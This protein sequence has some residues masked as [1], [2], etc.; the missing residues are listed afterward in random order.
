MNHA[1]HSKPQVPVTIYDQ[2]VV[3]PP[4]YRAS[5]YGRDIALF[6][7]CKLN[8]TVYEPFSTLQTCKPAFTPSLPAFFTQPN[9]TQKK[10][11][12]WLDK[13]ELHNYH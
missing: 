10:M 8:R 6:V 4:P 7:F 12:V 3:D 11:L 13:T 1:H 5:F 9:F 2:G